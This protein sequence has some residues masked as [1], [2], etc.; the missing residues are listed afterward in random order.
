MLTVLD[1]N[2]QKSVVFENGSWIVVSI[3]SCGVGE[4]VCDSH[5]AVKG[6]VTVWD[7]C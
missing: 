5:A 4:G 7:K 3:N 6:S 2:L 1:D